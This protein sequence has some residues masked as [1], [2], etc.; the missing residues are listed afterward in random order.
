MGIFFAPCRLRKVRKI[1]AGTNPPP[2]IA[3]MTLGLNSSRIRCAESWHIWC[4]LREISTSHRRFGAIEEGWLPGCRK[5]TCVPP[6]LVCDVLFGGWWEMWDV[7]MEEKARERWREIRQ[8]PGWCL[9]SGRKEST[10]FNCRRFRSPLFSGNWVIHS[11]QRPP[12][13]RPTPPPRFASSGLRPPSNRHRIE[14]LCQTNTRHVHHR[15][16]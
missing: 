1:R 5:C 2:P 6:S 15:H 8:S 3:I 12:S 9:L 14:R 10:K 16:D 4:I 13:R 7:D 11:T